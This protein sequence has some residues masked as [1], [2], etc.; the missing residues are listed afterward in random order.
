MLGILNLIL[1]SGIALY[2]TI[3]LKK[4]FTFIF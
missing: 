4:V 1:Y 2:W 3:K